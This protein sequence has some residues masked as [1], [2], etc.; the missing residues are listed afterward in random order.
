LARLDAGHKVEVETLQRRLT[1]EQTAA[2]ERM[3]A[4]VARLRR[5]HDKA[6]GSLKEEQ[7]T[8]LA[9]ERQAYEA[10]TETKER[11]HRNE[12]LGMRRRHEDELGAAE[13][14]RQRDIA[15]QE[16]RRVSELEGAE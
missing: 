9:S 7:A 5:E 13:E 4:E 14:R 10:L 12:I 2:T 11:D 1:D 3:T 15:E 16:A 6:L 8:Q